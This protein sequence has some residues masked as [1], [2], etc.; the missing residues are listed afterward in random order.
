MNQDQLTDLVIQSQSGDDA[1]MEQLLLLAHAPVS[2]LTGKI[3]HSS[4][5]AQQVT[6][7]VLETVVSNLSSLP[8]A[9]QFEPW[10]CRMTAA[11]CMQ[12]SPLLHRNFAESDDSAFWNDTLSDGTVLSEEESADAIQSMV[13]SLPESQRLCILLLSCGELTVPAIAQLTGFSEGIIKQ[14]IR[15]GQNT[16]QQHLW[17]LDSRGIQFSGVSSLT[18][19]LHDAMYRNGDADA[20]ME[21]VYDI[22]GKKMPVD[23]SVWAVRLLTIA[24]L[25][26]FVAVLVLGGMIVLK[27]MGSLA[28]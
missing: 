4:K 20:A 19:I 15:N 21:M 11:R 26:L 27:I 1:A 24:A 13:D 25:A 18:N 6:R 16:I 17:E 2:Y 8:E 5:T 10:L 23:P 3:L 28:G 22:L 9:N 7:D 12:A 14:N